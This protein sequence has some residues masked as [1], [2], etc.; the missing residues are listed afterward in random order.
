MHA[1]SSPFERAYQQK[2][3]LFG[4]L[5][6]LVHLPVLCA[7]AAFNHNSPVT[8]AIV[9]TILILGPGL[10]LL[11]D[12]AS[13]LAPITLAVSA[14]GIAALAIH[15]SNGLIEAHFEIFCMIAMLIVFGRIAP[16]LT[17][18]GT[19]ALHHTLFWIWLPSSVFNY[20]A[21]FSI[22][23]LHAFFVLLEAIPACWIA[24]HFGNSIT[25]HGIVVEHLGD[26][27]DQ[28]AAAADQVAGSSQS[29]ARDASQQ[30]ASIQETSAATAQINSMAQRNTAA[31]HSTATMVND[32]NSRFTQANLSLD[33]MVLAMDGIN[34]S[35]EQISRI[36]KVI[37]Q[38]AFQTNILALNAAVEA[39]RAGEAGMGFAVVADEVRSLAKR[40]A[41]AARDTATLIE[42]SIARS[43]AGKQKVDE[44]A[45]G[46]RAIATD[47]NRMKQLV[48]EINLGS[49]DQSR[50]LD[51]IARAV[52]QLESVTQSNAANA[53]QSAAAAEQLT[54]QSNSVKTLVARLMALANY[55]VPSR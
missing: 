31:S 55:G 34:A 5:F 20:K 14:M 9:C 19:I 1:E 40:S 25:A 51:Q 2:T 8:P 43:H 22:V 37:D 54:A 28:I 45:A 48:D 42:D 4:L 35:S 46:I 38:I 11:R 10:L 18:A 30:A 13:D 33:E 47:S 12:R 21:S 6:L 17:A 36:I 15:V 53:E 26:A 50:G 29:L 16:I 41:D 32:T 24:R 52:H 23:L 49:Q 3:N 39:A 27:A 44:V 7:V